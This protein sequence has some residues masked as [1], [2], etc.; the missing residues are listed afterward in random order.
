[1][2]PQSAFFVLA[3]VRSGAQNDLTALLETMN[4][5]P[6]HADPRNALVPFGEFDRLHFARICIV[7]DDTT[8]DVAAHGLSP[9]Q[10]PPYLAFV[11]DVD[12]SAE[13]FLQELGE[14]AASGL[15]KLFSHCEGFQPGDD[16]VAWMQRHS[17]PAS[18]WY[19]NWKGRTMLQIR[20]EAALRD[21]MEG[22]LDRHD[23]S[24]ASLNPLELHALLRHFLSGE[25]A[26]ARLT[27]TPDPPTQWGWWLA[28]AFGAV[29]PVVL[30]IVLSPI[31][32]IVAAML[33]LLV[34]LREAADPVICPRVD[35]RHRAAIAST[36]DRDV[37]NVFSAVGSLKPGAVRRIVGLFGLMILNYATQHVYTR[38][39]LARVRTIHFARWV[40]ID[41]KRRLVFMSNYDGSL[42][43]Y[44]DDFINK[45]GFGLNFVFSNGIGYPKTRWLLAGGCKDEQKFKNFLYRHQ[46]YTDVWYNAH[47]GLT[48][49]DLERNARIRAGLEARSL[50]E[51]EAAAWASLL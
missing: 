27:M 46:F 48:A 12:E 11:G 41:G 24:V 22:Y 40:W 14:R 34:R 3:P 19:A 36:E 5:Q 8:A 39:R 51:G 10:Y 44:M 21:A 25:I 13:T 17:A 50:S 4:A 9:A 33:L 20:E 31:A 47:R 38:G 15:T 45:A 1:M 16:V 43:S 23:E 7:R 35:P 30:L 49:V 6:G 18:A 26:A 28:N 42:E 37:T 2:T 29:A 32:A